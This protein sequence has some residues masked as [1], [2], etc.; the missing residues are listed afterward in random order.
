MGFL[1][2]LTS[3]SG[4]QYV[5]ITSGTVKNRWRYHRKDRL[6]DRTPALSKAIKKYGYSSFLVET[7]V[8]ADWDS[9]VEIEKRAI[10]K[11]KTKAPAGYNLTDGGEGTPGYKHTESA[12]KKL[13]EL[14]TGRTYS[15]E[16]NKK[17]GSGWRG[18]KRPEHAKALTGRKRPAHAE[19]M[20][21]LWAQRKANGGN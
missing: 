15:E 12:K 18:K 10:R 11:F 13:R 20:R 8:E 19:F 3:P 6:V 17:K 4:K 5:G 1:Y 14:A 2:R 9:L 16:T 7:L 21:E